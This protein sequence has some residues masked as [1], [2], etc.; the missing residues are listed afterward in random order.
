VALVRIV[1]MSF[2]ADDIPVFW[3]HP[4]SRQH[5]QEYSGGGGVRSVL[6]SVLESGTSLSTPGTCTH[7]RISYSW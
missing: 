3:V 6:D 5:V 2:G 1:A 4:V 7:S